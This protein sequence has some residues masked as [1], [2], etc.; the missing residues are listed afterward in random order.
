MVF[1]NKKW[2]EVKW[3]PSEQTDHKLRSCKESGGWQVDSR[4]LRSAVVLAIRHPAII[5]SGLRQALPDFRSHKTQQNDEVRG[6]G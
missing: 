5:C 4:M 1:E 3:E 6:K 2:R